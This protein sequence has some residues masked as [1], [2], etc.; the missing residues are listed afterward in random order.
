M[1]NINDSFSSKYLRASDIGEEG[2]SAVVTIMRVGMESMK[3]QSGQQETRP[4]LTFREFDKPLVLNKTNAKKIASLL[5]SQDTDDWIDQQIQL[6][7]TETE[8]GGDTVACIRVKQAALPSKKQSAKYAIPPENNP[9][10]P[11]DDSDIPF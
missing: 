6:F 11:A 3:N 8:F 9:A 1:P 2:A 7:S 4:T 5:K 10:P